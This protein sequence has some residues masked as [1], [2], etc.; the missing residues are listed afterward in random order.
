QIADTWR[1]WWVGDLMGAVLVAPIILVWTGAA[2]TRFRRRWP[3]AAGLAAA[4]ILVSVLTFF[5]VAPSGSPAGDPIR[6]T[7]ML[8]PVLIWAALRFGQRGATTAAFVV[9]AIAIWGT[10]LG[11]GPFVHPVLHESLLALQTFMA[12]VAATFLV[13]GA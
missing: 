10:A 13:M 6:Q 4:V 9:S 2:R 11:R 7:Y 8:F 12:V 1:A 3:E 5:G